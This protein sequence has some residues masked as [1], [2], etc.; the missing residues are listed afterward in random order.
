MSRCVTWTT[1]L[2][3]ALCC[4]EHFWNCDCLCLKHS[5][6]ESHSWGTFIVSA[7][8]PELTPVWPVWPETTSTDIPE[9]KLGHSP[10]LHGMMY[11]ELNK[12]PKWQIHVKVQ[13]CVSWGTGLGQEPALLCL[14]AGVRIWTACDF[15]GIFSPV[16]DDI[17]PL[18]PRDLPEL[19]TLSCFQALTL[20]VSHSSLMLS[21]H[22]KLW[23]MAHWTDHL[24][25]S[26]KHSSKIPV[27][28]KCT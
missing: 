1:P 19:S 10:T 4:H 14:P 24:N 3:I 8:N 22:W 6:G 18:S 5:G 11:S 20:T 16:A 27:L 2:N 12:I 13:G 9:S 26:N 21:A 17:L 28:V 25:F 7:T 15:S 23:T